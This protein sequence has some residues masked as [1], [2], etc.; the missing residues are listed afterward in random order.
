VKSNIATHASKVTVF[1]QDTHPGG[2]FRLGG[3][4]PLFQE[5]RK[6]RALHR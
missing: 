2:A 5:A 1:E 3:K 4:V 6:L